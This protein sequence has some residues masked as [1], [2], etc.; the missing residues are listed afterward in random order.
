MSSRRVEVKVIDRNAIRA[1]YLIIDD[2]MPS[3]EAEKMRAAIEAHFGNPYDHS[4]KTHM[5]WNY[6]HVPK[7]YT[8]L[9]S[10]PEIVVGPQLSEA[11]KTLLLTW[12]SET[13]GLAGTKPSYISLYVDGCRQSQ[14]NDAKNGRFGFVYSL[15]K[16]LRKTSGGETLIWREDDYFATRMHRAC[17]SDAFFD[18]IEPRFNRLLVFDDRLPHAV[19]LVEGNMDPLEGRVVIHGHVME[20]GPVVRGPVPHETVSRIADQLADEYARALGNSIT[21]YHGPASVRFTVRPDG[22]VADAHI[23]LDR[24]RRLPGEGPRVQEMLAELVGRISRLWF[25]A[26]SEETTITLPFGFG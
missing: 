15:T 12:T 23:L 20:G 1:P 17:A 14:H 9:R 5:I 24:V 16:N 21:I 2:F 22:S 18:S 11:F 3:T 25:P 19:Q 7:L 10:L 26:C 8:Y 6:W 13:L 4:A